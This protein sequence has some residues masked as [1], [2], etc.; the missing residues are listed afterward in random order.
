MRE[1]GFAAACGRVVCRSERIP[2]LSLETEG[3]MGTE[4]VWLGE[5]EADAA[6]ERRPAAVYAGGSGPAEEVQVVILRIDASFLFGAVSQAKVHALMLTLR[7]RDARRHFARLFTLIELF[8]RGE[9]KQLQPVQPP[10]RFLNPAAL[11]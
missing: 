3:V 10:L 6:I 1:R 9:L 11:I 8:Y 4:N 2:L 7:Y 5:I